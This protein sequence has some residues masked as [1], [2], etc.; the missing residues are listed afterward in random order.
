MLFT[1]S[2]FIQDRKENEGDG[3]DGELLGLYEA[4]RI[5]GKEV[6]EIL[7]VSTESPTEDERTL[8]RSLEKAWSSEKSIWS[9]EADEYYFKLYPCRSKF[10]L[11]LRSSTPGMYNYL[12]F[13]F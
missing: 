11:V 13:R 4:E 12:V 6:R 1:R 7:H 5:V 8:C 10:R 9:Y 3:W 2:A